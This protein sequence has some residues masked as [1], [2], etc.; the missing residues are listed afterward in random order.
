MNE[1][2][3][4]GIA[5]SVV[6]AAAAAIAAVVATG[7]RADARPPV[8]RAGNPA[9]IVFTHG[10]GHGGA[11]KTSPSLTWHGGPVRHSTAVTP[12]FW[13][14][15]NSGDPKVSGMQAFYAGVGGSG[16]LGTNTEYTDGSG[17]VG[18]TVSAATAKFDATATSSGAPSTSSVLA[19][20]ARATNNSPTAGGY[21]PVYSDQPRGHANYCAWH[22]TGTINGIQVQIGFFFN[23]DGDAGCDP[24]DT[25]SGHSQGVAALGNVSGHELSEM[26][27]DPQLN[28]WYDQKGAENA[29]KCAW[30]FG[31]KLLKLGTQSWKIQGNWSNAAASAKT[32]YTSGSSTV[33]GCVDGT[34]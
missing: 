23:L 29:D 31:A 4:G 27:T 16:Y 2:L 11:G 20:V 9:G 15:W 30:T 24:N 34:N 7:A 6:V 18:T 3:R 26:L 13:G 28:A 17:H 1:K 14:H 5:T 21:Y 33:V 8:L 12:I 10:A 19:V 32:G 25:A 22:S